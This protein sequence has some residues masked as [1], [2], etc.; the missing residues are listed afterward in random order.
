LRSRITLKKSNIQKFDEGR[1]SPND[2]NPIILEDLKKEIV[3]LKREISELKE[4][5]TINNVNNQ[6]LQVICIGNNDN[7]LDMLTKEYDNFDRALDFIKDCA[8]SK[9]KP[10]SNP[11]KLLKHKIGV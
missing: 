4:K 10:L 11:F 1:L 2:N 8:L 6:V 3:G 7:Y 5:T 9:G